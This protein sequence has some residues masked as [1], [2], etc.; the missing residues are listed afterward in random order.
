MSDFRGWVDRH[1]VELLLCMASAN[2]LIADWS[3]IVGEWWGAALPAGV[4]FLLI[5]EA[6]D[7]ARDEAH[8]AS[9]RRRLV[10]LAFSQPGRWPA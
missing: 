6:A 2:G 10:D 4:C 9:L 3:V 8:L 7:I 1:L 5:A